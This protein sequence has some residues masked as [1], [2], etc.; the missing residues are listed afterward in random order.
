MQWK[1]C[2]ATIRYGDRVDAPLLGEALPVELMNTV[3]ADRGGRHDALTDP[4][5]APAP[6]LVL[7]GLRQPGPGGPALRAAPRRGPV[8]HCPRPVS[9]CS[10]SISREASALDRSSPGAGRPACW[11]SVSR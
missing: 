3:W 11:E 9:A 8:A 2:L 4:A 1:E 10:S 5:G 6:R 7:G